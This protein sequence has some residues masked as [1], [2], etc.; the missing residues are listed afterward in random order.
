EV[1]A[2][3][4]AALEPGEPGVHHLAVAD[5]R[6]DERDVDADPGG[7]RFGDRREPLARGGNLDHDVGPRGRGVEPPPRGGGTRWVAPRGA[8]PPPGSGGRPIPGSAR[9]PAAGGRTPCGC[10]R[11]PRSRTGLRPRG[12]APRL[13]SAPRRNRRSPR[14]P[15]GRWWD[16]R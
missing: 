1:A 13:R 4:G 14:W 8:G 15:A 11:A 12:R 10:P 7:E 6:E 16:S 9:S 2:G 5:Q 3:G